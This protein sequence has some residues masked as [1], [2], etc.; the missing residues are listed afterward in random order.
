MGARPRGVTQSLTVSVQSAQSTNGRVSHRQVVSDGDINGLSLDAKCDRT[1]ST[2]ESEATLQSAVTVTVPAE[3]VGLRTERLSH[4]L[5]MS[6]NVWG[7]CKLVRW[8]YYG[9]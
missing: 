2:R 7:G 8:L 3:A 4:H 5:M 1:L 9:R 6:V